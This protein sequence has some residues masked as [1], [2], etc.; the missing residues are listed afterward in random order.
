MRQLGWLVGALALSA[1]PAGAQ[2]L[3]GDPAAG[4]RLA[5]QVCAACH[6]M[7]DDRTTVPG[8]APTFFEVANHPTTT[9]LGLRAF[10]QSPHVTMPDLILT[11]EETDDVISYILTLKSG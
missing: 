10:L 8:P 7:G 9:A 4:S 11:P 3:Q 6:V 1:A 5:H 2:D